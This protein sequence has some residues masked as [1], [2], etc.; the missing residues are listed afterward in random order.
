MISSRARTRAWSSRP[1][2]SC[3]MPSPCG[4][5]TS[6][7]SR[8][9]EKYAKMPCL[10]AG[11][12]PVLKGSHGVCELPQCRKPRRVCARRRKENGNHFLRRRVRRRKYRSARKRAHWAP[13][14]VQCVRCSELR[15][16]PQRTQRSGPLWSVCLRCTQKPRC[17]SSGVSIYAICETLRRCACR[18][19][20]NR[21]ACSGR[22][23]AHSR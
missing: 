9:H 8:R 17:R 6:K 4:G 14:G 19:P 15:S 11:H 12:F 23:A 18:A 21:S 7:N 22:G 13:F 5:S 16:L 20:E 3:P 10:L 1:S 2:P